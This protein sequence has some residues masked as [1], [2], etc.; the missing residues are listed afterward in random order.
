MFIL[1]LSLKKE[2]FVMDDQN[3]LNPQQPIQPTQPTEPAAPAQ[4]FAPQT[5][6]APQSPEFQQPAAAPVTPTPEASPVAAAQP[7]PAF[8]T[9][10]MQPQQP[11][12]QGAGGEGQ[13]DFLVA[14]LLSIFVGSL[15]I[16]RFYL[17]YVGLGILKL[18]TLGGCGVW[19]LIDII[20][21]ALHKLPDAKGNPLVSNH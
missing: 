7:A 4:N 11:F 2:L 1:C 12:T 21:I 16:D 14:L 10:A 6:P 13:K 3:S 15:G 19:S 8:D 17:G 5:P 20:L 9:P 18:V